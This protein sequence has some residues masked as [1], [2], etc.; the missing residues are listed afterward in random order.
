MSRNMSFEKE[1]QEAEKS[2]SSAISI[3][4][5]I[6]IFPVLFTTIE[7]K[8]LII[9]TKVKYPF[10]KKSYI[11]RLTGKYLC[12]LLSVDFL[13]WYSQFSGW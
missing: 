9:D 11:H 2:G 7:V 8:K 13:S 3:Y 6:D 10:I 1:L 12:H 4:P 5:K